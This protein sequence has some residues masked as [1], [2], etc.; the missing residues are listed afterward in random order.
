MA[1]GYASAVGSSIAVAVTL[2]KLTAGVTKG[3]KGPRLLFLNTIVNGTAGGC[4]SFCNTYM[5]RQAEISK[6]IDVYAD[7][8]LTKKVGIS[9]KAAS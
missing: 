9:K 8:K 2:R 3:A 6:G 7:E 5:M 4:A 1:L